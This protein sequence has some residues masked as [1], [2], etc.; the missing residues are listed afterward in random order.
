MENFT[1]EVRRQGTDTLFVILERDIPISR[2][3]TRLRKGQ[4]LV[5]GVHTDIH[6]RD[7][8]GH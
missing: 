7:I 3:G 6:K 1:L 5:V 4:C 2:E 8:P